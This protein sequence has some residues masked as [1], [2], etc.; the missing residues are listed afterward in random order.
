MHYATR[1]WSLNCAKCGPDRPKN[2]GGPA[3]SPPG[4]LDSISRPISRVHPGGQKS[5]LGCDFVFHAE[6]VE[7]VDLC[8]GP[9]GFRRGDWQRAVPPLSTSRRYARLTV[10]KDLQRDENGQ[11]GACGRPESE[12]AL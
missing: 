12:G 3:G 4:P 7:S 10:L 2:G 6:A 9:W 8:G 1:L 5:P 11:Q